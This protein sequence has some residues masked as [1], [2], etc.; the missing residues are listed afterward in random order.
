MQVIEKEDQGTLMSRL[1]DEG[2]EFPLHLFQRSGFS[3][4]GLRRRRGVGRR[5]RLPRRRGQSQ[6]VVVELAL[7]AAD[8]VFDGFEQG[9]I[10]ARAFQ[11]LRASA[12]RHG[13]DSV[14][15][16]KLMEKFFDDRRLPN[17]G[18]AG[19]AN[20]RP[21]TCDNRLNRALQWS[22]SRLAAHR[23]A[24]AS[25][26]MTLTDDASVAERAG[27]EVAV[28]PGRAENHKLTVAADIE[29]ADRRVTA[30]ALMELPDIRTGQG[31]DFHVFEPG[32]HVILC[33]VKIPHT[34]KLNGHSDA[35]AALHALT[36][37]ILGTIGE[38]DIG[39]H[40]PP[41]D[42]Q[43]KGTASSVF[44]KK[45]LALLKA[46]GGMIANV[47]ITILAEAPKISPHVPAMRSLLSALLNLAPDRIAIKATTTEKMGAIGRKEGIAA[48]ATATVRL[49]PE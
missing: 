10:G 33:G 31:I 37:A 16:R 48:F 20:Q 36:D 17:A 5:Q 12:P 1:L 26:D 8:Q 44:V 32:K 40:F 14:A 30:R 2:P 13:A 43:W 24:A 46:R 15:R 19:H 11:S 3:L 42:P 38:G 29:M 39:T 34:A 23:A 47:D 6:Q 45:A 49:P 4:E 28:I 41:T 9:E 21:A 22:A 35:D 27:M 25:G 18:L 7:W